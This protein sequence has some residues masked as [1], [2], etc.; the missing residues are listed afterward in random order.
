MTLLPS[1]FA[2]TQASW[3]FNEIAGVMSGVSYEVLTAVVT[4]V[5]L[6]LG[7]LML[8]TAAALLSRPPRTGLLLAASAVTLA[9]FTFGLFGSADATAY[10]APWREVLSAVTTIMA[11]SGGIAMIGLLFLFPNG[12]FYSARMRTLGLMGLLLTFIGAAATARVDNAWWFFVISLMLTVLLGVVGQA[13]QYRRAGPRERRQVIGFTVTVVLLPIWI[14]LSMI[15]AWPLVSFILPHGLMALLPLGLFLGAQRGLWGER[16]ST[17][18]YV[19]SIIPIALLAIAATGFWWRGNQPATIDT[20]AL[21][22]AE[23]TPVLLDVDMAM[24]DVSALLYLLQHPAVELRAITVNG[25]AFAHC[26]GGVRNALGLLEMAHAPEIPVACG[27]EDS[28][29]GGTPAPEDWR[30]SAD[31]LYGAQVMTR[32]RVADARPAAELLADTIQ[33]EP[34]KIVVVALGPLTNLAEA[35]QANPALAGQIK[36][37][38]IMGGA[39]DAPGNVSDADGTNQVAEWNFFADPVAADIVLASGAPVTLVPLDA[40]NDVPFTHAYYQRLRADH[41]T[42]P[43][44]FTYNLLYMNQWWLD[45]GMYWWDTLTAAVVTAP[46]LVTVEEMTLDVVTNEGPEMGRSIATTDGSPV[47]V[48][49]A[50]DKQAFEALFLAVLNDE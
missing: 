47:R 13:L 3:Q 35:F 20:T 21:E 45:G 22:S 23:P 15:A 6:A 10:P 2:A 38:I 5:R 27:R 41:L 36:A 30:K 42:R 43:A 39:V 40:T 34:G 19:G 29:P 18:I 26:D 14:S 50:A 4:G 31:N 32:D 17:T 9:P 25:V 37:L 8:A 48:A 49:T 11:I 16:L 28:Y 33:A 12:R 7:G 46:Q 44:V 24:D 1:A